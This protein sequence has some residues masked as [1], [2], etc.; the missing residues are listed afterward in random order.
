[1]LVWERAPYTGRI[2]GTSYLRSTQ[3]KKWF[4]PTRGRLPQAGEE[5]GWGGWRWPTLSK[6]LPRARNLTA[7]SEQHSLVKERQVGARP[8]GW[9]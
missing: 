8:P 3:G 6:R 7:M 1:M 5:Q 4:E 9:K 2:H